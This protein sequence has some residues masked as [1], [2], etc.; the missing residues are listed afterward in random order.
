MKHEIKFAS[1]WAFS[2]VI[3]GFL[4]FVFNYTMAP[5]SLP[6]YELIAAPAMFALSFFSEETAFWPKFLIFHSGQYIAYFFVILFAK[7]LYSRVKS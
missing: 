2:G 1:T 7:L 3:L 5:I 6:G 4:A